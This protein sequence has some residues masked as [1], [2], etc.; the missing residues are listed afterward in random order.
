LGWITRRD[1][2]VAIDVWHRFKGRFKGRPISRRAGYLIVA[3]VALEADVPQLIVDVP[4]LEPPLGE[5]KLRRTR[6]CL[7]DCRPLLAEPVFPDSQR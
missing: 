4:I 6:W 5:R 7:A 3:A 2:E 1:L